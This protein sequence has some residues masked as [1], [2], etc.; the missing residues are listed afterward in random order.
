MSKWYCLDCRKDVK[1]YMDI[2]KGFSLCCKT[3]GSSRLMKLDEM[4]QEEFKKFVEEF[5][6]R[7]GE[8]E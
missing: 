2:F 7:T 8:V 3:C 5:K 6:R 4:N 1:T